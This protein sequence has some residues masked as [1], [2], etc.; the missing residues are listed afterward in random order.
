MDRAEA[1]RLELAAS[2]R[3]PGVAQAYQH[4]PPYPTEVFDVLTGL[5]AAGPAHVLDLGAGEGALARPLAQRVE[6]VDAVD[7]SAAMLAA[8]R[9]RPGGDSPNLRWILGSAETALLDG[10]Y[11]L[12]TAGASLHWMELRP[13]LTRL[14][15]MMTGQAF[16]VIVEHGPDDMPWHGEL[17]EVIRRHSRSADFDRTISLSA[18]LIDTG[19][20]EQVG[21][22]RTAPVEFRQ[23][24]ASYIEQFHSTS[25]LAR[26]LMPASESVEFDQAITD[27]TRPYTLDGLLAMTVVAN[28]TWGRITQRPAAAALS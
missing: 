11:A 12:V 24:V 4:R 6:R 1:M 28:L 2:F 14:A 13:T 15:G 10:P 3:Y 18:R 9:K 17:T 16:L 26:E 23:P 22:A 27:L 7:I 19:L 20:F 8:G 21:E 25:S 5:I